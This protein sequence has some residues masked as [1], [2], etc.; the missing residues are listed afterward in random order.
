M[1]FSRQ[2]DWSGLPSPAAGALPDTGIEPASLGS[3][4]LAGRF[5]TTVPPVAPS[6]GGGERCGLSFLQGMHE[7][8]EFSQN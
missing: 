1:E 4:E 3:P 8:N 5:L 7:E 2:E 6:E